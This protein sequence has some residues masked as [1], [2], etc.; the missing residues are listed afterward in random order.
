LNSKSNYARGL[1]IPAPKKE[2]EI[3]A[4]DIVLRCNYKENT[5][6]QPLRELHI[7]IGFKRPFDVIDKVKCKMLS[8]FNSRVPKDVTANTWSSTVI[9]L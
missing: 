5:R 3:S 9:V 4:D 2:G 7:F 6:T 1:L 8:S